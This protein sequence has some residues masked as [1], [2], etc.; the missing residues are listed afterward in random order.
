MQSAGVLA[1]FFGLV[2][3]REIIGSPTRSRLLGSPESGG[4]LKEHTWL[5]ARENEHPFWV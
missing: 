3:G 4:L 5:K 2:A 1:G